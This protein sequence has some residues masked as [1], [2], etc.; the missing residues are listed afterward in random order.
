MPMMDAAP[1]KTTQSLLYGEGRQARL[2]MYRPARILLSQ[3]TI[4][5]HVG[6]SARHPNE[7]AA[8]SV[9][10]SACCSTAAKLTLVHARYD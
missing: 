8:V 7:P 6:E 9:Y 2:A 1:R 10:G 4:C 3:S 5:M